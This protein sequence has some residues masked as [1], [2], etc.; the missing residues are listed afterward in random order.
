MYCCSYLHYSIFATKKRITHVTYPFVEAFV[1]TSLARATVP[2][3]HICF[4]CASLSCSIYAN[5]GCIV[6]KLVLYRSE[7]GN[8][9]NTKPIYIGLLNADWIARVF[10]VNELIPNTFCSIALTWMPRSSSCE[11]WPTLVLLANTGLPR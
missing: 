1:R 11:Y 4:T 3:Y 5:S 8:I 10:A 9:F 2:K 6:V 7:F